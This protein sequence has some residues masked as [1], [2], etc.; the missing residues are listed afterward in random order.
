MHKW[1]EAEQKSF[2]QLKVSMATAPV[3]KL[4]DFDKTFVLTTDASL[5]AVGAVLE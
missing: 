5:V 4:P 2:D 1:T 3:L